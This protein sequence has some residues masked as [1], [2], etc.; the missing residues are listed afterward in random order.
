MGGGP[1]VVFVAVGADAEGR[2]VALTL[3]PIVLPDAEPLP[4]WWVRDVAATLPVWRADSSEARWPLTGDAALL[5]RPAEGALHLT[6]RL[7]HRRAALTVGDVAGPA[8]QL[9]PLGR[10]VLPDPLRRALRRAFDESAFYGDATT[11]VAWHRT[12]RRPS[13]AAST[14]QGA[15][16]SHA[17]RTR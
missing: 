10:G 17:S 4:A 9:L 8:R 7:P 16:L 11:S 5:A 3:D 6:L 12:P 13:G 14:P 15:R 1:A 2:A